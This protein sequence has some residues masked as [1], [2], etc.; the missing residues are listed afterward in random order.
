MPVS[1]RLLFLIVLFGLMG[2]LPQK[3]HALGLINASAS[4]STSRPSASSPLNLV[5]DPLA[6]G[7]SGVSVFNNISTYLSSDSAK[8]FDS[9]AFSEGVTVATTSADKLTASFTT[10]TT[11]VHGKASVLVVPITAMHIVSFT[12]Q[13]A[14][15]SG[16]KIIISYPI[17]NSFAGSDTNQ[18]SPSAYTWM[19][20]GLNPATD[21]QMKT[22]LGTATCSWA[23]SGVTN[24]SN[25]QTPTATCTVAGASIPAG[26]TVWVFV[27]CTA[28]TADSQGGRCTAQRPLLIN[29]TNTG[30]RGT[31]SIKS[32]S[33]ATQDGST[34]ILDQS[35]VKMG[36]I[37]SVFVVAHVDPTFSF[38][39]DGVAAST[40]M[41]TVGT[42]GVTYANLSTNTSFASTPT[43]V[44]L[45]TI[46]AAGNT[47]AAQKMTLRSNT[48][49]GYA[50][51]AT[52][53]GFL[54][55]PANGSYIVNAQ[56]NVTANNTPAPTVIN[57]LTGGYGVNPC[58]ANSRVNT[59]TWGQATPNFANPSPNF[60]YTLIN[61]SG[62]PDSAGDVI[63]SVYG[64]RAG[65]S[66]PPGDYWQ[67]ITYTASVTF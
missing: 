18:A 62:A 22:S 61:Y 63:Y 49:V 5:T 66:T 25:N 40:D 67:I 11:L 51:T 12:P 26:A 17:S 9:G 65:G 54:I 52:A 44:N 35:T 19:F 39:I 29:P 56:G 20:N 46:T 64:V 27:G 33:I 1:K 53:S 4:A 36:T 7:S 14:I 28:A 38:T 47:Y 3:A 31:A 48:G 30:T 57:A 50:I 43:E 23:V 59:T 2:F 34:N 13:T 42:C 32:V 41:H 58:D 15:P 16:G 21:I 6:I 10:S 8:F 37:E 55:N 45:G 24:G 60:Y